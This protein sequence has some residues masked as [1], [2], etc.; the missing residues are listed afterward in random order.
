MDVD[1]YD[2][3]LSQVDIE[4]GDE[5]QEEHQGSE[6]NNVETIQEEIIWDVIATEIRINY[7]K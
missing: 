6:E 3:L 1:L 4:L 5:A 2:T 7:I